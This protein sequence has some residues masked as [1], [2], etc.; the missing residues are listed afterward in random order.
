MNSDCFDL[1]KSLIKENIRIRYNDYILRNPTEIKIYHITP[2]KYTRLMTALDNYN[3]I[4]HILHDDMFL[5]VFSKGIYRAELLFELLNGILFFSKKEII[6]RSDQHLYNTIANVII[7][8]Q[9]FGDGN[10]RTSLFYLKTFGLNDD[11]ANNIIVQIKVMRQHMLACPFPNENKEN[12][13]RYE[14]QISQKIFI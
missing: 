5:S 12:H 11:K 2:D 6:F 7:C 1:F 10:H 13:D 3:S 8:S 9:I 14:K 4:Q